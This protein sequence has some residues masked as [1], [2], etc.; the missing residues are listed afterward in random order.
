MTPFIEETAETVETIPPG[1]GGFLG[2]VGV[3]ALASGPVCAA[4]MLTVVI[5]ILPNITAHLSVI[6]GKV[7]S[8]QIFIASPMLGLVVGGLLSTVLFGKAS[9]RT[10]FLIAIAVFGV[11]GA[12]G[13]FLTDGA[14]ILSR[15][16]MGVTAAVIGAASTALIGERVSFK[17]R[18]QVLGWQMA[19]SSAL[20]I[21]LMLISG[22][23]SDRFGWRTSFLMFPAIAVTVI[24]LALAFTP[25]SNAPRPSLTAGVKAQVW[26]LLI[27]LWPIYL[28]VVLVNVTAFTTNSQASYVLAGIGAKTASARAQIM[29]LNQLMIVIA[30]IAFPYVRKLVGQ[31]FLAVVI[32]T[33]MGCGMVWLGAASTPLMAIGALAVLGSGNG[34]L[35]P[36]QSS[37]LLTHAPAAVRGPAAGIMV[38]CQFMADAVNPVM[39]AP[40]IASVGLQST[41]SMIGVLAIIAAVLT[42]IWRWFKPGGTRPMG[43]LQDA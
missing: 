10:I 14:L 30:A 32:I 3:A 36:Y 33:L 2:G 31:R 4:A 12:L 5:P 28:F 1:R 38:S 6:G 18:P 15:I 23:L 19:A 35:F 34:L 9:P 20:A 29:S 41:I 40:L 13:A 11:T 42:L 43:R 17:R 25:P 22:R 39:L 27:K 26:P 8:T 7:L 24:G 21:I 16:F 37:M